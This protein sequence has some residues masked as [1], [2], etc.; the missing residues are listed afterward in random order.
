MPSQES[1]GTTLVI[2]AH[3]QQV[4]MTV[5]GRIAVM[6]RGRIIQVA[7]PRE[8]YERPNSRW[9]ADFIGEVNL[10]EGSV[11]EVGASGMVVASAAAGQLHALSPADAIVGDIV[12]VALQP[13]K[14]LIAHDP[15]PVDEAN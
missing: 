6:D 3:E 13:E 2:V 11:I 10:I 8:I 7:T 4:A 5:A 15:P 14:V 12:W 1:L 9:V